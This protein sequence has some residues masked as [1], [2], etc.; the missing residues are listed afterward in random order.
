MAAYNMGYGGVL[1]AVH[2]LTGGWG[3]P[4]VVLGALLIAQLAAVSVNPSAA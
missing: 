3:A 1:Q 4:L 2:A